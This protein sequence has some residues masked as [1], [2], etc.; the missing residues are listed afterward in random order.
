MAF[1]SFRASVFCAA[2]IAMTFGIRIKATGPMV[3]VDDPQV[4]TSICGEN[5]TG[6][7]MVDMGSCGA[8]CCALEVLLEV[9]PKL[10][11]ERLK[12]FLLEGGDSR[13]FAHVPD[14]KR[15]GNA[16]SNVVEGLNLQG[17]HNTSEGHADT[18]RFNIRKSSTGSALPIL[19]A[20]S[21]SHENGTRSDRGQN[22]KTLTY[23][24]GKVGIH[25]SP[26]QILHGCGRASNMSVNAT[27]SSKAAIFNEEAAN[28]YPWIEPSGSLNRWVN[29]NRAPKK[30]S[31][32][33]L[34]PWRYVP[35]CRHPD[36]GSCGTA[37]CALQAKVGD[38]TGDALYKDLIDFLNNHG[39]LLADK[40]DDSLFSYRYIPAYHEEFTPHTPDDLRAFNT[41]WE[42]I[43]RGWHITKKKQYKDILNFNIRPW[44]QAITGTAH[45]GA[46]LLRAFSISEK[47][48]AI[49]DYGQNFKNL[50][51]VFDAIGID[52]NNISVLYGC[53]FDDYPTYIPSDF[54]TDR[55]GLTV[56]DISG[57]LSSR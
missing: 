50:Q 19:R 6:C 32:C 22:Y 29:V 21:V 23:M 15:D 38:R 18:L 35:D 47:A 17:L 26:P 14:K 44:P 57:Y 52:R 4:E 10:A 8:A 20:L 48:G 3:H 36:Q 55:F 42:W 16:S 43:V 40:W 5:A 49:T 25:A 2:G 12:M 39:D 46:L 27:G 9:A 56:P 30:T 33:G 7:D 28:P 11:Y 37:C 13:S 24:L 51:Y 54:P 1:P 45:D 53:A 34:E 41:D 31:T